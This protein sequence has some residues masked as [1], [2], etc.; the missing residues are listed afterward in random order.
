MCCAGSNDP[1]SEGDAR[2]VATSLSLG[3]GQGKP[4]RTGGDINLSAVDFCH[5]ALLFWWK[6]TLSSKA[7]WIFAHSSFSYIGAYYA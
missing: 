2:G 7:L 3:G 1:T 6:E 5:T 4:R